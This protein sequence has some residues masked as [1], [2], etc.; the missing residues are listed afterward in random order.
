[1]GPGGFGGPG[2]GDNGQIFA[3][4]TGGVM[5][6]LGLTVAILMI[7][8]MAEFSGVPADAG[9]YVILGLLGG[10]MGTAGGVLVAL[11]T[12]GP[13]GVILALVGGAVAAIGG[14]LF[15]AVYVDETRFVLTMIFGLDRKST[16]LNSSHVKIS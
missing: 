8:V 3:W 5:A 4:I 16:R 1:G 11:R 10:L 12:Q 15:M 13:V 2:G 7:T 6:A 9:I 14:I